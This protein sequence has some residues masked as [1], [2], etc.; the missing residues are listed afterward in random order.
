MRTPSQ[1]AAVEK[2]AVETLVFMSSPVN[3]G[4]HPPTTLSGS[5][6]RSKIAPLVDRK[7]H[8]DV[9]AG[10]GTEVQ[11]SSLPAS[12]LTPRSK[13]QLSEADIDKMLDDVPDAS[14]SE[15]DDLLDHLTSKQLLGS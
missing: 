13:P 1:Q 6:L 9:L 4:Y 10:I 7:A 11:K 15:D 12:S 5:P 8:P 2:D 3:L 14:S